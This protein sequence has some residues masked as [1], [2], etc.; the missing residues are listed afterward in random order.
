VAE[1]WDAADLVA[2]GKERN[3]LLV[4]PLAGSAG[5]A[6]LAANLAL[7]RETRLATRVELAVAPHPGLE[8]YDA[9]AVNDTAIPTV[10]CRIVG[11]TFAYYPRVALHDLVL[12]C[13][14]L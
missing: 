14:G 7:A 11:L 10:N 4:E 12:T 9:I 8:L 5:A 2:T 13:E 1:A 6:A 3:A